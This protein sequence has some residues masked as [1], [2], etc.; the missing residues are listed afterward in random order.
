MTLSD[1]DRPN[2]GTSARTDPGYAQ[3]QLA[4]ALTTS[5]SHLD[6]AMRE[7]AQ[8]RVSRWEAVLRKLLDG[9]VN[10]GSRTP[11]GDT[12]EWVSLEVVTGGFATGSLLAGGPLQ[13]HELAMLALL[14]H[15][16]DG[17]VHTAKDDAFEA[18][19]ALNAHYLSDAGLAELRGQLASRTY[20][21]TVPEEGALLVVAWLVDHGHADE[22]RELLETIA[23]WFDRLR[24]Y[25]VPLA[26]PG[27]RGP[28]VRLRTAMEAIERLYAVRP[29]ERVLAQRESVKVWLPMHD[30]IV[31]LFLETVVDGWPCRHYPPDWATRADRLLSAYEM[32]R[33]AHSRCAK[34]EKPGSHQMQLR[35]LLSVCARDPAFLTGREVG[36]I[37]LIIDRH[38]AKHGAPGSR[39]LVDLRRRQLAEVGAPTY[40]VIAAVVA[41]RLDDCPPDQGLEDVERLHE[42]VTQAEAMRTGAPVGTV[43]ARSIRRKVDRC[44]E[45]TVERLVERGLI[46][47]GE[48]IAQVLPQLT[49]SVQAAGFADPALRDLH[50]ELYRAFR[51]RRSLLLLN[52]ERQVRSE[53]LPWL[54][55]IDRLRADSADDRALARQTLKEVVA[56]T[57][58]AFPQAI[59]P[60][61]LLIELRA[62]ARAA[63]IDLPL[64]EEL[65]ADIFMGTFTHGALESAKCA[66]GLL[67]GSLYAIYYGI[68]YRDISRMTSPMAMPRKRRRWFGADAAQ[69]P[70]LFTRMCFDRAGVAPDVRSPAVNGTIIEQQQILTTHNLASLFVA[71][72]LR[73]TLHDALVGMAKEV[74]RWSCRRLRMK[75]EERHSR[76]IAIKQAAYAWRQMVFFLSLVPASELTDFLDWADSY[77]AEQGDVFARRFQ[78]ALDG[79]VL[80]SRGHVMPADGVDESGARRFIGWASQTHWLL[81]DVD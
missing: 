1:D 30:R 68:D 63:A 50:A 18:R 64:V 70:D 74:F 54:A 26:T 59:I 79:L 57:L 11:V 16:D 13:P 15:G 28:R 48:T 29:S 23:P 3:H 76:L 2:A 5:V 38:V 21:L 22:A 41:R 52:L 60:N 9:T 37:R 53:E 19:L 73:M 65:A 6:P 7:R 25:P 62:L 51:R 40:D 56:M 80:A 75:A 8:A 10:P 12:P 47:S 43:I 36:R 78:P 14:G 81:E 71:L 46:T 35:T 55:A 32:L 77:L 20:A 45:G 58:R 67:D 69:D 61:R 42:A 31:A 66:A 49:A 34:M 27:P 72:G 4:K 33:K 24:F 44:L 17:Q 39:T